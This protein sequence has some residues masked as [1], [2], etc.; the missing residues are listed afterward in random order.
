MNRIRTLHRILGLILVA[1]LV[2]WTVTGLL[3]FLKP[4]WDDAYSPLSVRTY[5]IADASVVPSGA[6]WLE[7]RRLVDDAIASK[8]SRYGQIAGVTPA[9]DGYSATLQTTTGAEIELDWKRLQLQQR[10]RD[11][12]RIDALYRVHYLQW[13][14]IRVLDQV[15]G[16]AGIFL[17]LILAALG[18]RMARRR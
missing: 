7:L 8:R 16:V 17:L 2:G 18:V 10:G 12:R 6:G 15:L 3:F 14:G 13:T 5:P 1:P 4:G 11:T 9:Q